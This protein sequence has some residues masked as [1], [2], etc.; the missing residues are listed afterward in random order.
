LTNIRPPPN[1]ILGSEQ[2]RSGAGLSMSTVPMISQPRS[3]PSI[4]HLIHELHAV[5]TRSI[6][7]ALTWEQ[8][9]SPPIQYTLVRPF[10]S[11]YAASKPGAHGR[12]EK[13]RSVDNSLLGPERRAE[14]GEKDEGWALGAVLYALMVNRCVLTNQLKHPGR[15][16]VPSRGELTRKDPVHQSRR[17]GS[18]VLCHA[19]FSRRLLRDVS[20]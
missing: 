16:A 3:T 13:Q 15:S 7:S 12:P 9:N 20:K 10:V 18:F 2:E 19:K 14:V 1:R 5:V 6:D 4:F 17:S 8:L 11:K